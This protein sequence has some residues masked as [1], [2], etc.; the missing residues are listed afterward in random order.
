VITVCC[1]HCAGKGKIELA[2]HLQETLEFVRQAGGC[3]AL[4]VHKGLGCTG[5]RSAINNRLA[6]LE[7]LGLVIRERRHAAHVWKV[8]K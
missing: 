1:P 7:Q 8:A 2:P 5:V 3:T 4:D 6:Y